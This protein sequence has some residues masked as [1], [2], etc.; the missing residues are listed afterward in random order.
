MPLRAR[1]GALYQHP[2]TLRLRERAWQYAL[3]T[4]VDRPIGTYLLLW[5]TLW[6]LWLAAAGLPDLHVLVVFV[7]GVILMRAAGCAINDYADRNIDAHVS[8]TVGRPLAT[9]AVRPAEAVAVAIVLALAAFALVLTLNR[10]TVYLSVGAV[11]LAALYPFSKRFTHLPQV[12]LGAAF[13]WAAPMAFAAQTGSVP[14]LAWLV[15]TVNLI[16]TV[17]YDTM[18]AMA[19]KPDDERIGVKST[20]ILFGDYD[21][22]MVA[23]LQVMTLLGLVL[24]GSRAGLGWIY[25][26]GVAAAAVLFG[27]QQFLINDRAPAHCFRA[28]LNNAWVGLVV[29]AALVL[30]Y[31]LAG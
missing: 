30:D 13:S 1:L 3:L 14:P 5:P 7:L 6:A 9:G 22:H 18:Y 23:V 25:Y 2:L 4:R 11:I 27:Y 15:F 20:A 29:F 31:A 16:W 19:D 21:R 8:R 28:F 26:V 12:F 17:A 10:L 24:I